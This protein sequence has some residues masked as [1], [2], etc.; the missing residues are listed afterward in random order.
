[1]SDLMKRWNL[2]CYVITLPCVA[3]FHPELDVSIGHREFVPYVHNYYKER[4]D[5]I[6]PYFQKARLEFV[7]LL[8]PYI[9]MLWAEPK[10]KNGSNSALLSATPADG[11]P[12]GLV[13]HFYASQVVD[14]LERKC[15]SVLG[16]KS[17]VVEK[18]PININDWMPPST[19]VYKVSDS[20]Y[21]FMVPSFAVNQLY[22]PVRQPHVQINFEMPADLTKIRLSGPGLKKS[23][24][25]LS[26]VDPKDG[27]DSRVLHPLGTLKGH[28][29]TWQLPNE[30]WARS[31]NTIKVSAEVK[32]PDR[33]VAISF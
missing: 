10:L 11:H 31:V 13:T 9:A 22:M 4:Y 2:P 6:A 21:I 25:W 30:A 19:N 5:T 1:M 26:S 3:G 16:R 18:Y 14:L 33:R 7:N 24:I 28:D 23:T 8:E 29:V 15:P 27:Y 17:E 32:G 20:S 12:G